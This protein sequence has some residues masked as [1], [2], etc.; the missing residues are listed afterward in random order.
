[1]ADSPNLK[2]DGFSMK[3][4]NTP[5]QTDYNV[6]TSVEDWVKETMGLQNNELTANL[7]TLSQKHPELFKDPASVYKT[8]IEIKDNPTHFFENNR[9]DIAL[10]TK[11]LRDN[12]LGKMGV[13]KDSGKIAHLSKSTKNNELER[14]QRVNQRELG[15]G[16]SYP[17]HQSTTRVP[18]HDDG[19]AKALSPTGE[20][21]PNKF[22][23][24]NS[25]FNGGTPPPNHRGAWNDEWDG[26]FNV[27][28]KQITLPPVE[29]TKMPTNPM[30]RNMALNST[31][32]GV[33]GATQ[34]D[35]NRLRGAVIG[36]LGG[37]GAT[38]AIP[39]IGKALRGDKSP[40]DYSKSAFDE[41]MD[42]SKN[43]EWK[44]I[45]TNDG[46]SLN[47]AKNFGNR[48]FRDTFSSQYHDLRDKLHME[49]Q[50]E[51]R[52][53]SDIQKSLEQLPDDIREKA[54]LYLTGEL[55]GAGASLG[56]DAIY[57]RD[58]SSKLLDEN[59][60]KRLDFI[61]S[62]IDA[63]TNHL[64]EL[65]V[66]ND[67]SEQISKNWLHRTYDN[68]DIKDA[69]KGAGLAT[70]GVYQKG[71]TEVISD[72][73]LNKRIWQ[74]VYKA[75]DFFKPFNQGGII[76]N[77]L[78]NGKWEIRSDYTFDERTAMG[79][80]RD[81]A[82]TATD[83]LFHQIKLE[84]QHNFFNEVSKLKVNGKSVIYDDLEIETMKVLNP[85]GWQKELKGM[86]YDKI[87]EDSKFGVL[88]GKWIRGDI[89]DD[90]IGHFDSFRRDF[91]DFAMTASEIVLQ[92]NKV[93]K[94]SKTIY[95]PTTHFNNMASN[96]AIAYQFGMPLHKMT[97]GIKDY[98]G[99]MLKKDRYQ[100]LRVKLFNGNITSAEKGE[101]TK[102]KEQFKYYDEA[103]TMGLFGRSQL[104]DINGGLKDLVSKDSTLGK[105]DDK[106]SSIYQGEDNMMRYAAF[107]HFVSKGYSPQETKK[108][109]NSF[110]P[111]YTKPLPRGVRFARDTALSPFISWA[112]YVM[113]SIAKLSS[114]PA[115][116]SRLLGTF[117]FLSTL[118]MDFNPF[119]NKRPER[120]FGAYL[121]LPNQSGDRVTQLKVD[122]MVPQLQMIRPAEFVD[123]MFLQGPMW[124]GVDDFRNVVINGDVPENRFFRRPITYS[125]KK[126]PD[127]ALDYVSHFGSTYTPTPQVVWNGADLIRAL[128]RDENS[129]KRNNTYDPRSGM[130]LLLKFFPGINTRNY[131]K[132]GL[133]KDLKRK[134]RQKER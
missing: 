60:K 115:G 79:E 89:R 75:E 59:L 62:E 113:P 134:E 125:N 35:E 65:G 101:L 95:N 124:Q 47:G 71:K 122:R 14:L 52:R 111:D 19:A 56:K 29:P 31:L 107:K 97:S 66:L 49:V 121:D 73:E 131:S 82:K 27:D 58:K 83:S 44:D 94:K 68:P 6:K 112:Y 23:E 54:H 32:G 15:V 24:V 51:I 98:S 36:A 126:Q 108:A 88:S 3:Q 127:K 4:D 61:R 76:A 78:D 26:M 9:P 102:L 80:V 37:A 99:L 46:F 69:N 12:S 70:Q 45:S 33:V 93:M 10:I 119:N 128:V 43:K 91:S 105:I 110:M 17:T 20:I 132:S 86:G 104:H 64:K 129:R 18:D 77:K 42:L 50:S 130:Q 116:F 133:E 81:V 67:P 38:Y 11:R 48:N 1:M 30:L 5:P 22:D 13:V 34:D 120:S 41:A 7:F 109:I 28:K 39:K 40:I 21:I 74:G 84:A 85:K 16:S 114:T 25:S 55:N 118:G 72:D 117:A 123:E 53:L 100:D 106:V 92:Y 96:V 87:P 90:V 2:G 63:K 8:I 103:E 57:A